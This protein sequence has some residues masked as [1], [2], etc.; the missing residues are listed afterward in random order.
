MEAYTSFKTHNDEQPAYSLGLTLSGGGAK[1]FAHLGVLKAMEEKG[2]RPGIIS[3]TSAGALAGVLYA[4]GNSP[5]QILTFFENKAFKEFAELTIPHTGIFKADRFKHFLKKHLKAETFEEL[6]IPMKIVATDIVEGTSVVFDKGPLVPAVLASCAYPI[7]F[8]PMEIDN[9]HYVD[10][11]LFMN[12]PV[13]VIR[14]QCEVV[15]GVNAS[16]LTKQKFKN[17]LLYI[18]ERSFHY[19]TA[20][21]SVIDRNLCDILIESNKLSKFAMF[22]MEDCGEIFEIGYKLGIKEFEKEKNAYKIDSIKSIQEKAL[23]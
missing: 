18:A 8:T 20:S 11:G 17:S 5:D 6:R 23:L 7:V 22:T 16:P 3:G 21:N 15:I 2:L 14:P 1:G 9:V 10:G 4:D 13:R 19:I 12:F